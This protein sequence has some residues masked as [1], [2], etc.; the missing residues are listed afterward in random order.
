M[1]DKLITGFSRV[2]RKMDDAAQLAAD[3]DT[4]IRAAREAPASL[5]AQDKQRLLDLPDPEEQQTAIMAAAAA[6]ATGV[7]SASIK[8]DLLLRAV[9]S[10]RELTDAEARL[11]SR[12]YWHDYPTDD[13]KAAAI[14][15]HELFDGNDD[16]WLTA[17]NELQ[18]V[19]APLY[20]DKNEAV[21]LE[22]GKKEE[23]RRLRERV[24]GDVAAIEDREAKCL[25][26][27]AL[28]RPWVRRVWQEDGGFGSNRKWGFAYFV[29]PSMMEDERRADEYISRAA[30]VLD[31]GRRAVA[32]GDALD[33]RWKYQRLNWPD[34]VPEARL[35]AAGENVDVSVRILPIKKWSGASPD[36][37]G[38][39]AILSQ[40]KTGRDPAALDE[41][42]I[43]AADQER[44]KIVKKLREQFV[45]IRDQGGL[46]PG[47]LPNAF[48]VV[49]QD[50]V[51]STIGTTKG[52]VDWMWV[53]A[54]DPDYRDDRPSTNVPSSSSG[55][56]Y[57]GFLRVRLQQLVN[58]FYE[59]RRFHEQDWPMEKLWQLSRRSRDQ[60]F[61]SIN[62][63]ELGQFAVARDTGSAIRA[64]ARVLRDQHGDKLR[65]IQ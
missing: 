50:C 21:A 32:C 26:T 9:E 22:N 42:N 30:N 25:Q 64:P 17:Y 1:M 41:E 44:L 20:D 14:A 51:D 34:G 16:A 61:F 59:L 63:G 19:R 27:M 35:R 38:D 65:F 5:S 54:V 37:L 40:E 4:L 56:L 62:E 36:G 46:Q 13:E 47:V 11:L 7:M 24:S 8:S 29:V 28:A 10:P 53:W 58:N 48:I 33:R 52:V 15:V 6:A 31:W 23:S 57:G 39:S 55:Q 2:V 60:L 43:A 45:S 12:R 18:A 49:D 3:F